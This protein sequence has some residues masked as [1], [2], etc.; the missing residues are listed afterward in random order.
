MTAGQETAQAPG[1]LG[2]AF[3]DAAQRDI[4]SARADLAKAAQQVERAAIWTRV[5]SFTGRAWP[6]TRLQ[7]ARATHE[8]A[9]QRLLAAL[10][11]ERKVG[12][13][14]AAGWI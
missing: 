1:G 3:L 13:E 8:R 11:A 4:E 2:R 10:E 9:R 7:E 5:S 14:L 6:A 12:A